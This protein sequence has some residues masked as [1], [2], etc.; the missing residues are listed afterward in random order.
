M[1]PRARVAQRG[2][3]DRSLRDRLR[4]VRRFRAVLAQSLEPVGAEL[5][6]VRRR[7][8][9]EVLTSELLPLLDACRFLE[10]GAARVLA[11]R[12]AGIWGRP[13]WLVG[14]RAEVRREPLGVVLVLGP[15][16]YP[17]FLPA[18]QVLQALVAGNTVVFKPAPGTSPVAR[19]LA[20]LL[21]AAGLPEDGMQVA[22]ESVE[23][24]RA[25][26]REGAD[27]VVLTGS[28]ETGRSVLSVLA[29]SLTPA[30]MEL[31]GAD[32]MV[33]RADADLRLAASALAYGLTLNGGATCIAPRRVWVSNR[34]LAPFTQELRREFSTRETIHLEDGLAGRLR[35]LLAEAQHLGARLVTGRITEDSI[36]GPL[37]IADLP[38]ASPLWHEQVFGPVALVTGYTHESEVVAFA[39]E[40]EWALG[41]SIFSREEKAARRLADRLPVGV[42]TL[43]DVIVPTADPRLPFGGR[44]SSGFG[45]TRGLEGLLEM[46]ASKVISVRR[47]TW[48]PH[49]GPANG[50]ERWLPPILRVVHADGIRSRLAGLRELLKRIPVLGRERT[51]QPDSS[52]PLKPDPQTS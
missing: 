21:A 33:V 20:M 32:L 37:V 7:P 23:E 8:V 29:D 4:V 52:G 14:A 12:G 16:N 27:K 13:S 47:G 1:M 35:P 24:A 10:R 28:A 25:L 41:A 48:R 19:R 26:L 46:T 36:A 31:S 50:L 22:G 11:P 3:G 2:W 18:C 5:A 40:S 38:V 30:T 43:N 34:V 49:F 39:R 6:E 45:R 17:L 44:R 42:V 15:G 9:A 51:P